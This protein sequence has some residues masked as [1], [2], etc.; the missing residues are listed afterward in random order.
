MDAV[1]GGRDVGVA[2]V[3]EWA[4]GIEPVSPSTNSVI[5][6]PVE[7]NRARCIS[8]PDVESVGD[9]NTN[10][11]KGSEE[12]VKEN[13]SV[14]ESEG[15]KSEKGMEIATGIAV[16]VEDVLSVLTVV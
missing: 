7:R 15:C 9:K 4:D 14:V 11:W 8:W 12:Q 13:V 3:R 16:V 5:R 6:F 1:N 2:V 10:C